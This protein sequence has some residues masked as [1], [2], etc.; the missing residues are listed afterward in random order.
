MNVRKIV[1]LALKQ[2]GVLAAGE[3]AEADELA[4]A[5]DSLQCLLA[6]WATDRLYVH[7]ANILTLPIKGKGTYL[8]GKVASDCCE[9]AVTCCGDVLHRPD[10]KAE[11]SHISDRAWLDSDEITLIRDLNNTASFVQVWYEV[12]AP[13][14]KFHVLDDAKELKIKAYTLPYEL[15]D[16]DELHLPQSYERPLYLSL[17]VEIAPMF[18]VEPSITLLTNQ[19]NAITMLKRGNSTPLYAKNDL[20]IGVQSHGCY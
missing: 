20:N 18:G 13:N 12:D 17:A 9:Y 4:D 11:I 5:L 15:C 14:W 8:I 16:H 2:L 10:L 19:R 7:K 1:E 3:N 6:Q